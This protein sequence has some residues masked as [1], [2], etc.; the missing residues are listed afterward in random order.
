[1]K[2]LPLQ[3]IKSIGYP[4]IVIPQYMQSSQ[5]SCAE[6]FESAAE[7]SLSAGTAANNTTAGQFSQGSQSVKFAPPSIE[8]R[9]YKYPFGPVDI[10]NLERVCIDC[11]AHDKYKVQSIRF[12]DN[13]SHV[14]YMDAVVQF[15]I[16]SLGVMNTYYQCRRLITAGGMSFSSP[17]VEIRMT[18]S[19]DGAQSFSFDNLILNKVGFG[20]GV[21]LRFD[22]SYEVAYT[23]LYSILQAHHIRATIACMTDQVGASGYLTW[24][25]LIELDRKGWCIANHANNND[26]LIGQDLATQTTRI[27]TAITALESHGLTKGS[28]LLIYPAATHDDTTHIVMTNLSIPIGVTVGDAVNDVHYLPYYDYSHIQSLTISS[29]KTVAQAEAYLDNAITDKAIATYHFHN[30]GAAGEWT[31]AQFQQFVDYIVVKCK[32]GLLYPITW[33]D[34]NSLISG[35]VKVPRIG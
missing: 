22:D 18:I 12:Y 28:H 30:V 29:T 14:N 7:W 9:A 6:G 11:Y 20:A 24:D 19:A 21:I 26:S 4:S 35:S 31:V 27:Q 16:H 1:M 3:V 5:G 2:G 15:A 34:Y 25:Q 8:Q 23:Q 17:L 13:H 33:S 10:T 32:A